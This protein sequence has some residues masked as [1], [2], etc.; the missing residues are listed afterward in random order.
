[1]S[2]SERIHFW[3]NGY[4]FLVSSLYKTIDERMLPERDD[5]NWSVDDIDMSVRILLN[6]PN[7][8][9]DVMIKYIDNDKA[10]YSFLVSV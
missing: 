6:E 3:T 8:L 9:Y 7:T 10:N 5:K 4:P 1:M 2:V